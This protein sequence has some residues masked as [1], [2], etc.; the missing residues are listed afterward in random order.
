MKVAL[1]S[2]SKEGASVAR[3]IAKGLIKADLFLHDE[4]EE[5]AETRRF[6]GIMTLT[7]EI[8]NQYDGLV[9]VAPCGV[10]VRAIAPYVKNKQED[11]AVLVIDV[12][13]RFVIS[14]LSGHE[15]GANALAV[16][17]GNIL[18]AEP[19]ITTTTEAMKTVIVGIGCRKSTSVDAI[20]DAIMGA[21]KRASVELSE[22]RLLAS[23][24]VKAKEKGLREASERLGI[25]IRFISSEE[26]LLSGREFL[27]SAFVKE[28]VGLPAVAEPAALLA[29]RRTRLIL[30]KTTYKGVTVAL[31]RESSMWSE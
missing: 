24:D 1:I 8:F 16:H 15:G 12:G 14:L 19:V 27:P 21:L 2:L 25:P 6:A 11:P 20:I 31:A 4:V 9:Y 3:R 13:A 18:G 29:G 5:S 23:A 7:G 28:N 10:A 26:I 17:V 22:V 30:S